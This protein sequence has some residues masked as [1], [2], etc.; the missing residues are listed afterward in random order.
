MSDKERQAESASL[1]CG[2]D[3]ERRTARRIA[4]REANLIASGPR[5]K[6]ERDALRDALHELLGYVDRNSPDNISDHPAAFQARVAI[7]RCREV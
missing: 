3:H 6:A 1:M 5:W 2:D 4:R 7:H